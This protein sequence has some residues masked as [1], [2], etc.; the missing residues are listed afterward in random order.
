MEV[1]IT[2]YISYTGM[3]GL[4]FIIWLIFSYLCPSPRRSLDEIMPRR[5]LGLNFV[6][7]CLLACLLELFYASS[8]LNSVAFQLPEMPLLK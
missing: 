4:D 5:L 1:Y 2:T 6:V 8:S 7:I 3:L